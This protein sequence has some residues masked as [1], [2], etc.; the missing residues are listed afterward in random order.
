MDDVGK[1]RSRKFAESLCDAS[2]VIDDEAADAQNA[3]GFWLY[4]YNLGTGPR[5]FGQLTLDGYRAMQIGEDLK[6]L[7]EL[8]PAD[9]LGA[10]LP[11]VDG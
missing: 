7:G 2:W 6:N 8:Q 11:S 4:S 10:T 1:A 5:L 9:V 3:V